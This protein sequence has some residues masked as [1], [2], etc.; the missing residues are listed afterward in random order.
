MCGRFTLTSDID[1]IVEL[2]D[3]GRNEFE[4][5]Q[6]RY[7][8]APTNIVPAVLTVDG[9]RV[10][11][12]FKWGLVPF[13]SKDGKSSYS[14]IN[15]RAESILKKP[16]FRNLIDRKRIVLPCSGYYEWRKEGSGKQPYLFQ[17]NSEKTFGLAG[18]YDTWEGP[19]KNT[20]WSCTIITTS[21]NELAE[22]V[23]DR[24]PV[25]LN[26]NGIDLW[27]DTNNMDKDLLTSLLTSYP[28]EEMK[29]FP[30]SK[31]VNYVKNQGEDLI[32]EVVLNSK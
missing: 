4:G 12:G 20:V 10:L 1:E 22:K 17:L 5:Y 15:A 7:N 8:I 21:P 6:R 9:E 24:M 3:I 14:M 16:A 2:F 19:D 30:V 11:R 13:W 28:T 31:A 27:L 18:L 25:I 26:E 23:H 29:L 32:K